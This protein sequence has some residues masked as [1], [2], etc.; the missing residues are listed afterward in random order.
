M[1]SIDENP[2]SSKRISGSEGEGDVSSAADELRF[3]WVELV[4][5]IFDCICII[6]AISVLLSFVN[7]CHR[8]NVH[9][10]CS[11]W[12]THICAFQ[13]NNVIV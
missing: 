1:F 11:S 8:Y 5:C 2:H 4:L 7:E 3:V 12:N 6:V 13:F 9:F 10:Y